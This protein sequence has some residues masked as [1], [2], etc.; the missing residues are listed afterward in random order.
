MTI[1]EDMSSISPSQR[2]I[3]SE[4][5]PVKRPIQLLAVE[6]DHTFTLNDEDLTKLLLR[7]DVKDLEVVVVS[8]A[9]AFRKGKSFLLDF[10]LK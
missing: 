5:G 6:D 4:P 10:F 7:E 8:V 2:S 1:K 3:Q 9:G